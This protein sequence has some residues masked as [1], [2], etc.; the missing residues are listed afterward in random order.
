MEP[1]DVVDS[2]RRLDYEAKVTGRAS[3]LADLKVPAMCH[4]KILR[5]PYPHAR[6]RNIDVSKALSLRGVI[7][8]LT[9]DDI[10]HDQGIDPYYGPV[11]KDQTIVAVDKVR[12]V[13]DPVAAVAA[14]TP[15]AAEAALERIEVEYEELPA[16]T[17]V[18][19]AVAKGAPLLH[20]SIRIPDSGFADLAELKP[21]EGTNIC[22]HFKLLKGD[23]EKGFAESDYIFED[24]FTLPTTQHCALEPHACIASVERS[25]RIVVWSTTQNPFVVRTQLANIYKV[26]VS[27]VRIIV[28]YL[29]GGYGGKVYPK[30]E[31]LPVALAR[32]AQRPVKI[33][34]G[35]EEVFYTITKHAAVI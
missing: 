20:E 33:A 23:I 7:A 18:A 15:G 4:G 5:S 24:T 32:K 25:G 3:Y 9:R 10:L 12:H 34:L 31:P 22:T 26:P 29:G 6:I 27:T 28:T 30:L 21:V 16:V 19:A 11:F 1:I 8:V 14:L 35:R 13:G 2:V 17:D